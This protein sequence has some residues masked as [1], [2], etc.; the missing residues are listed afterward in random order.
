ML[1][2]QEWLSAAISQLTSDP[3]KE[4]MVAVQTVLTS[5]DLTQKQEALED[6]T[7]FCHEMDMAIGE[8]R[9]L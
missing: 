3:V 8:F 5:Q 4:M 7:D 9:T 2:Q 6:V 1:Q